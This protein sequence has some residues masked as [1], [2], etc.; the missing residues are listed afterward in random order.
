MTFICYKTCSTCKKAQNWLNEQ[1][2]SYT[3]RPIKEQNPTAAELA[4]WVKI[5][6][7]PVKRFINTSGI[8]YKS[9]ALKDKLPP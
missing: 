7:L 2:A 8:L 9:M 4:E 1:G 3:E 5:S 6:G